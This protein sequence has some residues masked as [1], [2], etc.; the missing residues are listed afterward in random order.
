MMPTKK[1]RAWEWLLGY[2]RTRSGIP[3]AVEP[4]I[5]RI[6]VRLVLL[7]PLA[8]CVF[9]AASPPSAVWTFCRAFWS[10]FVGIFVGTFFEL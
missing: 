7:L 9:R 5:Q 6:I 1:T 2:E 10:S 3:P 8:Q 4:G